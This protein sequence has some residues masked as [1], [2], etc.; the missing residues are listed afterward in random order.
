MS[1]FR[2]AVAAV[3]RADTPLTAALKQGA[4]AI[5]DQELP[6]PKWLY[7]TLA[8]LHASGRMVGMHLADTLLYQP[9][10]RARCDD[11][12]KAVKVQGGFPYIG[13]NL[14]LVVGDGCKIA[15]Q[16]SLVAGHVHERPTLTLGRFSNLG[17]GVVVSV[18]ESVTI[19]DYVRVA[20]GCYIADNAGH[21]RDPLR[22]RTEGVTADEIRPVV[23]EDDVW[24]G[25]G[26]M[27]MPGVTIGARSIV[28]AR[29]VV[30]RSV[31]PD[32]LVVGSP[33]RVVRTLGRE[34]DRLSVVRAA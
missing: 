21:P 23:I 31:P 14:H 8:E 20:T 19:G 25:A 11:V 10:F 2:N 6:A 9:M 17:P 5:L 13:G 27:V 33:G 24:L 34:E 4:R 7:G 28:G 22:R 15:A 32:S 18:G 29:T 26:A 30:T 12:G 1:R 16:T 3:K